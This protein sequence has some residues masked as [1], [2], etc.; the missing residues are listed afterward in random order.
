MDYGELGL[1]DKKREE[2]KNH[3]EEENG[4]EYG[5]TVMYLIGSTD[6]VSPINGAKG[7]NWESDQ[8]N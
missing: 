4:N 2:I 6:L 1:M 5:N 8:R 3:K 7:T